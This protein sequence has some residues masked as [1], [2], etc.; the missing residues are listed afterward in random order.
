MK[1]FRE[2]KEIKGLA[3][4]LGFFDGVHIGHKKIL[5]ALLEHAKAKG[6][7]TAVVTF[8][9]NPS[10]YFS[11]EITPAIQTFKDK[12][13]IMDSL[14]ID[15]IF[16]LDFEKY[17]NLE[18]I[19]YLQNILV[20]TFN[21]PVIV[22]GYNH[23]FGKNKV[24]TPAFLKDHEQKFGYEC[25]IVPEFKY[26]DSEEVSSSVIRKYIQQGQLNTAKSLLGRSFS[27]RNSV[28]KG[29]KMAR[30][31]GFPTANTIW[32]NTMVKLP[33]GVYFGFAKIGNIIKPALISWGTKPTLSDGREEILET[34]IYNF[35]E[36][37]YGKIINVIFVEKLRDEQ[38][39]GNISALKAQIKNDFTVFEKW[40]KTVKI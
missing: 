7:E 16:E 32:P 31:L 40:A 38:N 24:G 6:V 23:T 2:L 4:A 13:L 11:D 35:S 37:I 34:H 19:D 21:P 3:L 33:Y 30:A 9:K 1:I 22:V 14:G 17:K 12:E 36:D 27:V 18:A 15:Y 29:N 26:N 5:S 20:K 28:I 8:E 25:I 39:F 10:D